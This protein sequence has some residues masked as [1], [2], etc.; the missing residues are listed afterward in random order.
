MKLKQLTSAVILATTGMSATAATY[1]LTPA[2][3]QDLSFYNFSQ[4][5]DNTGAMVVMTQTEYN[6]PIDLDLLDFTNENFTAIF[7]D[8]DAVEQGVF[9][10]LDYQRMYS[11]LTEQRRNSAFIQVF[12]N[13]RSY[14]ADTVRADLLPGFDVIHESFNDYSRSAY[15]IA[16][17]SVGGDYFVGTANGAFFEVDYTTDDGDD[18]TYIVNDMPLQPFVQV[19]GESK[20]LT[21]SE[22]EPLGGYGEAFAVNSQLQV[23]G[24][25]S[26][27]F[28]DTYIT[29]AE[30]C[31]DDE[32]RGEVPIELCQY[33]LIASENTLISSGYR[34]ATIWDMD[35]QGEVVNTTTYGL[36]FEPDEDANLLSYYS[37]AFDINDNGIAV[38][39]SSTG[40]TVIYT[41]PGSSAGRYSGI[42][43]TA[44]IDGEVV[45]L[46]PRDENLR[47]TAI[48][49]N[50]DDWVVGNVMRENNGVA[51]EQMFIYNVESGEALYPDGFFASAAVNP[52]AINNFRQT[53]R[54][55]RSCTTSM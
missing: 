37:K 53:D 1:T 26:A 19:N 41:L 12:A 10:N 38:G 29:S 39:E 42:V 13:Y 7:D 24:Y 27:S 54:C 34:R 6:P 47:S 49:I 46:L 45:E 36:V 18:L 17:D 44:F 25:S 2:P 55:E 33:N 4:S 16:R 52:R 30:N 8:P 21:P 32:V 51:R 9:S 23:A 11:Y 50:N 15:T 43:A 28:T 48:A 35:T 3:V 20:V 14:N 22:S 40:E 5:I 31:E